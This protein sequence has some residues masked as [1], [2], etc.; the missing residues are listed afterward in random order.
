MDLDRMHIEFKVGVDKVDSFNS[1][2]FLT[3]EIDILLQNAYEEFIETRMS[4]LNEHRTGFEETQKRMD[5]LKGLMS[6]YTSN[7]FTINSDNLSNSVFVDLPDDYRHAIQETLI[8]TCDDG[9]REIE[10]IPLK[11]GMYNKLFKNPFTRPGKTK[12]Y[13]LS[14]NSGK[15]EIIYN[16]VVLDTYRLRYVKEPL[17]IDVAQIRN[18]QGL[19]GGASIELDEHT[20]REIVQTAVRM[21]LANI[22]SSRVQT[23]VMETKT[24]E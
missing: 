11:H 15:H 22:G 5:D 13:R 9:V 17:K 1:A 24:M 7:S 23:S 10:I 4:G 8:V 12:A 20:H 2:N 18:P 21:A 19:A 14:Y 3:E 6:T 16:D